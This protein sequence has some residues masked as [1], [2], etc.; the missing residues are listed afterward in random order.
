MRLPAVWIRLR[1]YGRLCRRFCFDSRRPGSSTRRSAETPARPCPGRI[2]HQ[3]VDFVQDQRN[4]VES[5]L[6]ESAT[7]DEPVSFM[8][9]KDQCGGV[10]N[11]FRDAIARPEGRRLIVRQNIGPAALLAKPVENRGHLFV[12]LSVGWVR[13]GRAQVPDQTPRFGCPS[14]GCAALRQLVQLLQTKQSEPA[15]PARTDFPRNTPRPAPEAFDRLGN[16]ILRTA[17]MAQRP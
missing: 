8:S 1:F 16:S 4:R 3:R 2:V 15:N 6:A 11:S 9:A 7:G 10:T 12:R 5:A 17:G 13:K 14:I